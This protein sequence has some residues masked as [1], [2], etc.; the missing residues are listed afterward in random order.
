MPGVV[1]TL[2][3]LRG[4]VDMLELELKQEM[5]TQVFRHLPRFNDRFCFSFPLTPATP[6]VTV[7][8][9]CSNRWARLTDS[10]CGCVPGVI[11]CRRRVTSSLRS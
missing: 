6:C 10:T 8:G 4:M 9:A 3:T 5:R 11:E 2:M 7:C 1:T